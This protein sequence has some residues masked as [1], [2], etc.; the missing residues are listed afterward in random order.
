MKAKLFIQLFTILALPVF[1]NALQNN[2]N[3]FPSDWK[4]AAK[5][6]VDKQIKDFLI[7]KI[8]SYLIY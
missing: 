3:N 1:G 7:Q 5:M 4:I 2:K 6:M 8:S